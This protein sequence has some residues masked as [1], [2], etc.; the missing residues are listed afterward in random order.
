MSVTYPLGFVASGVASGIKPA[1]RK[2]MA[3][4]ATSDWHAGAAAATFTQNLAA[5]A[6][7]VVSR[8]N[9]AAS[10]GRVAAVLLTSGNANA[11]TGAEGEVGAR[12]A[13]EA[14]ASVAGVH[15]DQV[16]ICSTGLIGIP[17]P[18]EKAL[19]G[20]PRAHGE[21]AGGEESGL[22]AAEAMM[23]TDTFAKTAV[24]EVGSVRFGGIAK[25]AAMIA[26]N[27][28]TM[29]AVVTTDAKATPEQLARVLGEAVEMS[30]NRITIDGCTSTNDTVVIIAS[31]ASR[32]ELSDEELSRGVR[33]VCDSL[34]SQIVFDAEGSTKL[35][36]VTCKGAETEDDALAVARKVAESSLVKCS[37]FGKDPYWG[38]VVS[39]VGT[40]RVDVDMTQ[41]SV[42]YGGIT[43]YAHLEELDHD[44][45]AVGRAMEAREIDLEVAI[46]DGA[47]SATIL[48]ADLTPAYIAENMRTS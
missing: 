32:Q 5:A 24:H 47:A 9:L 46:G 41:V 28:A 31:G 21:L 8:Q 19:E 42:A 33:A 35:I 27:M 44:R 34:A 1:R 14:L 18:V 6:P 12:R 2:D 29:L 15:P 39:E 26:P 17:W 13:V 23:T 16:L 10:G 3:L 4:V 20:I 25:G 38:R 43:V 45:E 48:T 22:A 30:F 11:A 7:V 36:R 37:F 40:A